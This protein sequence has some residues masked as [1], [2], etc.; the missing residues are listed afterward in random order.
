MQEETVKKSLLIIK[1][2]SNS[3]TTVENFL[4]NREWN[5]KST[6]NLKEALLFLVQEQ[7]QFVLVCIDHPNQKIRKLP[8]VLTQ[9]FPVCVI[10]F[11]EGT[12]ASAYSLLSASAT[13]Y[14]LYPPVTGPA[15]ERTVN[16]YYKDLQA[17]AQN[18][19]HLRTG[20]ENSEDGVI[21]IRGDSQ[22]FSTKDAQS[23]LANMLG[24]EGS[25]FGIIAGQK[26]SDMGSAAHGHGAGKSHSSS[27]GANE[28][29]SG[30]HH[31]SYHDK[32]NKGHWAPLPPK[33]PAKKDRLT[34]EQME[35]HPKATKRD[36]IILK[37]TK[38]ALET[39]CAVTGS[40]DNSEA[41]AQSTNVACIVVESSR[42]SGYL[43]T[44]MGKNK[45]IDKTFIDKVREKLFKFLKDNGEKI[46]EGD[47]MDLKIKQVPFEDWALEY[48]EFMRK[49]IHDGNEVAM[50]FFPR[51]DIKTKFGESHAEEMASIEIDEFM[52]DVKVEFNVYI[53]LPRNNKYILYT[54][55][56]GMFYNNQKERLQSQGIS[57]LHI[58]KV[59]MQDV[60]KYRAQNFL[61]EKIN[62]FE[63]KER[64]EAELRTEKKI[65]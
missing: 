51:T 52:G 16:K 18:P 47:S 23:I 37:G 60:D 44:A 21:A 42:F 62:E 6:T 19:T 39:S 34:P 43:I 15:V 31:S 53:R 33:P 49:S 38:E 25:D 59:D 55:R 65:A 61:N 27:Q 35:S 24:E 8:K 7:P 57:Q 3:L 46:N 20:T 17:R 30:P 22:G 41:I 12:S 32:K 14:M 26:A 54:P 64:K 29:A 45:S 48:A 13:E 11:T 5:I 2:Q 50:A 36:S 56:G 58:M 40:F 28:D 1:A 10:A 4:K 63:E 9:A